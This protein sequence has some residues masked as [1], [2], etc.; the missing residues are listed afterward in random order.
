M[1]LLLSNFRF[2]IFNSVEGG[3]CSDAYFKDLDKGRTVPAAHCPISQLFKDER[4]DVLC[5]QPKGSSLPLIGFV[6]IFLSIEQME[7]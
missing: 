7:Q 5:Q 6:R 2:V 1:N 3:T 4:D